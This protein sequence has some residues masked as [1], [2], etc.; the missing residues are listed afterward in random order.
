MLVNVI[1]RQFMIGHTYI[2]T[3]I[4][5]LTSWIKSWSW[6]GE[7]WNNVSMKLTECINS[8]KCR[9]Q[10]EILFFNALRRYDYSSMPLIF[11]NDWIT[12]Y[13]TFTCTEQEHRASSYQG[14]NRQ[15]WCRLRTALCTHIC[16]CTHVT[17][18]HECTCKCALWYTHL[19][20]GSMKSTTF[21]CSHGKSFTA[22]STN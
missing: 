15:V 14:L 4:H 16:V 12:T 20:L 18:V 19:N 8:I 2:H 3:H 9:I 5:T 11:T 10:K 17:Q 1:H 6:A 7:T 13:L 21:C 22:N